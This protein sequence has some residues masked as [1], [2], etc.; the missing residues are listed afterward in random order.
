MRTLA[1]INFAQLALSFGATRGPS[2]AL[3]WDN[4]VVLDRVP[5][6]FD[7]N[8][9]SVAQRSPTGT[10]LRHQLFTLPRMP[11]RETPSAHNIVRILLRS[12]RTGPPALAWRH[13]RDLASMTA[14]LAFTFCFFRMH[15]G[16]GHLNLIWCF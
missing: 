6:L 2:S 1:P 4:H 9:F 8:K 10:P 7:A 14:A 5:S 11:R 3:A 15:H 13:T 12:R 16:H